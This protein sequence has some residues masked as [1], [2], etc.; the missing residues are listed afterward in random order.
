[1]TDR[2]VNQWTRRA[3]LAGSSAAIAAGIGAATSSAAESTTAKVKTYTNADFYAADGTFQKDKAQ[4]AYFDMFRRF[5]YP[6]S[7]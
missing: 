1:M 4:E 5:G 3:M 7:G 2:Q 6:I